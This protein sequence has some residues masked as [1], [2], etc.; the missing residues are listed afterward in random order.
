M[1]AII[2]VTIAILIAGCGPVKEIDET[3]G[4]SVERL[5]N[6]A[7]QH[8]DD[9]QYLTAIERFEKLESRYPFGKFATQ[10][11]LDVAY[12]YYKFDEPESALAAVE[13]FIK[14]NPRHEAVDYAYYLRGLVNFDRGGGVLDVFYDREVSDYD[15]NLLLKSYDD[16]KLLV[17]RFADSRYVEDSRQR[18]VYLREQLARGDLKIAQYYADRSAWVAAAKRTN[19]I[20]LDYQGTT[21][22]PAA[23]AIQLRAYKELGL[24][25]LADD[26]RRIIELNYGSSS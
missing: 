14:L 3:A 24:S 7:R 1:R 4:W 20:L 2:L 15:R 9:G 22:I 19:A 16:F 8:L 23:L 5:Y 18:M 26:T 12:A 11:Q 6:N 17:R 25:E 21:V 13:R 10:A